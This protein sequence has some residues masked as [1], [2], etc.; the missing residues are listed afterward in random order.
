MHEINFKTIKMCKNVKRIEWFKRVDLKDEV[1][2][3]CY[4][5]NKPC[6]TRV[7]SS[8]VFN[9]VDESYKEK[10]INELLLRFNIE[11]IEKLHSVNDEQM[12]NFLKSLG[13]KKELHCY[14][15]GQIYKYLNLTRIK[16]SGVLG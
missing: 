3:S 10:F 9:S 8:L 16:E 5:R 7:V 4:V 15:S 6:N 12:I 13:F 1:L 14:V 2:A 11:S